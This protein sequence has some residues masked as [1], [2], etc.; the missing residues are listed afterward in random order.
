VRFWPEA[1]LTEKRAVPTAKAAIDLEWALSNLT[2]IN[3]ETRIHL[4]SIS[5]EYS[6]EESASR[7]IVLKDRRARLPLSC[8]VLFSLLYDKHKTEALLFGPRLPELS[9]ISSPKRKR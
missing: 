2:L 1:A 9:C 8:L 4:E 7:P 5:D 6:F 3:V